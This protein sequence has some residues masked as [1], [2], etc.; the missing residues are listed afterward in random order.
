[1]GGVGGI[2]R[3]N[4]Q[5]Q[6]HRASAG[7]GE[8]AAHLLQFASHQGEE[9]GGL[10]KRVVPDCEVATAGARLLTI[11][12]SGQIA[13]GDAV[14]V[15]KQHWTGGAVG[16]DPHP[17]ATEQ[18]G[19][20]RVEGDVPESLGL[21]LSGEQASTHVQPLKGGVRVGGDPHP[22]LEHEGALGR[23]Q[24]QEPIAVALERIGRQGGTIEPEILQLQ[25]Y[26]HQLQGLA[27]RDLSLGIRQE[28]QPGLHDGVV[29]IKLHREVGA[30]QQ[31]RGRPIITE[32]NGRH[33]NRRM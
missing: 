8:A 24:Q 31:E 1:M 13:T 21:A 3:I 2:T 25:V 6:H 30:L 33:Q 19:T 9:V 16:F 12:C 29:P 32:K 4:V 14:S 11:R 22:A 10:R 5:P 15:G 17:K 28:G 26:P 27:S 7:G 20:I 18:I 23:S